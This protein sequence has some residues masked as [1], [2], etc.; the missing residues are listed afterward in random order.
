[1]PKP[2]PKS[3]R[4]PNAHYPYALKTA[5]P[6]PSLLIPLLHLINPHRPLQLLQIR[7]IPIRI[8]QLH[9]FFPLRQLRLLCCR[10][11][12]EMFLDLGFAE[13]SHAVAYCY[14]AGEGGD[15]IWGFGLVEWMGGKGMEG[16]G[17]GR[18]GGGILL[19]GWG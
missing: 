7:P 3:K 9:I 4:H 6:N 8:R 13:G 10:R 14:E 5:Q 11:L 12:R 15:P 2:K 18:G 1:M 19:G 17:T 16:T